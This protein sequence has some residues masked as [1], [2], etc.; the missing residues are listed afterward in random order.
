MVDRVWPQP[1]L[2]EHC[3]GLNKAHLSY[4]AES[5]LLS[6]S[7]Q[8]RNIRQPERRSET[9]F[10]SCRSTGEIRNVPASV[11]RRAE[12]AVAVRMLTTLMHETPVQPLSRTECPAL[13]D[14]PECP[15]WDLRDSASMLRQYQADMR[16]AFM[17]EFA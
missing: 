17:Q 2:E 4:M 15:S 5:T 8:P 3:Q 11:G 10:W 6:Y 14:G 9:S 12:L 16:Q 7:W 13:I 1:A